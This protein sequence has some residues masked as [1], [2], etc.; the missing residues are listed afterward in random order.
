MSDYKVGFIGGGNM[1][2]ALAAG[3]LSSG[4]APVNLLVAEPSEARRREIAPAL[5]GAFLGADNDEVAGRAD[6]IVLAVKPQVMKEVCTALAGTV[7]QRRPLVISVAA[8]THSRDIETWL[9]GNL[10]VVRVMPNQPALLLRGASGLF[11]NGRTSS[12]QRERAMEI[13]AAVGSVVTVDNE[14]LIDAVT[15]ISGSGPAYF[16]LLIDVMM[17]SA[18]EFG[19]DADAARKLVMDTAQGATALAA[20][21]GE[22][23]ETMIRNVRSPGGTTAAA[24]DVFDAAGIRE[25]LRRAFAAARQ[26]SLELAQ[27]SKS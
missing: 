24:F 25:T 20:T 15:A 11:A 2:M 7:Q 10:A 12:Q 3:L 26:R 5:A 14:E 17:Q 9:G 16:Y 19:L 22:S 18:Q 8:G 13:V 6:C 23:M 4:F 1:A 21:C 27:G